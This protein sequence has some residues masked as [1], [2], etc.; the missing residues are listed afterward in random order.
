M[1]DVYAY[2]V[3]APSTLIEIRDTFPS[4]GGYAEVSAVHR[5]LG[6]EAAG[7]AYALARLGVA[8]K[9]DGAHIGTDEASHHAFETLTRAGV[10]CSALTLVD[11]PGPVTEFVISGGSSRTILGTYGQLLA[12]RAWNQPSKDD[13]AQSR[14]VCLDPFFGDESLQVARWCMESGTPYVTIDAPPD[15]EIAR[16]ADVLVIAGEYAARELDLG[17]P[18]GVVAAYTE[19]CAGSV[20][21]TQ[22]EGPLLSGRRGTSPREHQPFEVDAHDTTGAGDSFRG[23]LIYGMLQGQDDEHMIRTASA[24]AAIVCEQAPSFVNSPTLAEL[25]RFLGTEPDAQ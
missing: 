4:E 12:D 1:H 3:I 9:L 8:T 18:A 14:I 6:G 19:H 24:V 16:H 17:G 23:G 5:S 21:L 15:A 11:G 13:V 7:G 22:G 10:D 20:I 2:G 25:D